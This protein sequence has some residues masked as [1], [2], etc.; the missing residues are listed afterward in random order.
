MIDL[1]AIEASPV[2]GTIK[3]M[4]GGLERMTLGD[5]GRAQHQ[6]EVVSA[7]GKKVA[8]PATVL[9]PF[10]Y[11]KLLHAVPD[12]FTFGDGTSAL[13]A[14]EWASAM[15]HVNGKN[16]LTC[17]I[18]ISDLAVHWDHARALKL[19]NYIKTDHT[20]DIPAS[21]CTPSGL[22]KSVTG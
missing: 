14:A 2:D 11:W 1:K 15:T 21:L 18:P 12:L 22:P 19:I 17:G 16:G 6:R 10:R 5:I 20:A 13:R 7:V 3:G 8:S 4:P 9:N